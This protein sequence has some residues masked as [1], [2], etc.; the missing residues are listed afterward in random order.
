ME[1]NEQPRPIHHFAAVLLIVVAGITGGI[2][3]VLI[4]LFLLLNIPALVGLNQFGS[5]SIYVVM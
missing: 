5:G 4:A 2:I 3:S 1:D